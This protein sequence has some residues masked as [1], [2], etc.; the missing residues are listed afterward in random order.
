[1][2]SSAGEAEADRWAVAL[3]EAP[4]D[5]REQAEALRST[6]AMQRLEALYALRRMGL[7]AAPATPVVVAQL[8]D[9]TRLFVPDR[10]V[11]GSHEVHL[12][13]AAAETL[14]HIGAAVVPAV[15]ETMLADDD[16][17]ARALA[18]EV[19]FHVTFWPEEPRLRDLL[20]EWPSNIMCEEGG[21][22]RRRMNW[23]GRAY[24]EPGPVDRKAWLA[25][26]DDDQPWVRRYAAEAL[27]RLGERRAIPRLI[28]L[29]DDEHTPTRGAALVGLGI[30]QVADSRVIEAALTERERSLFPREVVRVIGTP[31][32]EPLIDVLVDSKTSASRR[33]RAGWL[34]HTFG[35][36]APLPVLLMHVEHGQP[37]VR[38]W[39][40]RLLGR[41][42]DDPRV[43]EPL[44]EALDDEHAEVRQAA[45]DKLGSHTQTP[46]E[47][48]AILEAMAEHDPDEVVRRRARMAV[49]RLAEGQK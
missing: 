43:L 41:F 33:E 36:E 4:A 47:V 5:V 44:V 12:G 6:D 35:D 18:A 48:V 2:K 37:E 20:R 1:M 40:I 27:G 13:C 31:A 34:L 9:R 19:Y 8:A 15:R 26:L 30:L 17:R 24:H 38:L 22:V 28:E 14:Q 45:V 46:P 21:R 42:R 7:A 49:E 10:S 23:A 3:A 16:G 39:V 29:L 11:L 32:V 25:A